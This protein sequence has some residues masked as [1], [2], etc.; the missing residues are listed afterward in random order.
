VTSRELGVEGENAACVFLKRKGYR[1]L[2]RNYRCPLGELDIIARKRG[3]LVF[4][5]VK[6]RSG[7]EP[8]E[9]LGAV[10]ATRQSRMAQAAA[11]Y[12]DAKGGEE[13]ECRFDV[14]ALLKDGAAWK[15]MHVEDAFE[16]G[17]L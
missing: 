1:I 16:I 3:V 10:D 8:E 6:A 4:C 15:I 13:R 11:H 17:E 9:A 12:L 2:D 5:E 7:G 14:I